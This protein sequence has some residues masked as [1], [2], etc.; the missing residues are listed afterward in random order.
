MYA[1]TIVLYDESKRNGAHVVSKTI[2]IPKYLVAQGYIASQWLEEPYKEGA[3]KKIND[4]ENG[5][6]FNRLFN[7][8]QYL[9]ELGIYIDT[10]LQNKYYRKHPKNEYDDSHPYRLPE[11]HVDFN[12]EEGLGKQNKSNLVY[13]TCMGMLCGQ[14]FKVI[15]NIKRKLITKRK[16]TKRKATKKRRR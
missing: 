16:A 4:G 2:K 15:A 10:K 11:L 12:S 14:G 5:A 6:I 7:E 1:I 13:Q 8:A 3:V 9:L